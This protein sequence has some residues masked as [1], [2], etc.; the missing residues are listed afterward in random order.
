MNYGLYLSAA[1]MRIN[2]ERVDVMANNLA[3]VRTNAFKQDFT[4]I[5]SR[6]SAPQE[7][8]LPPGM[9]FPVLDRMGGGLTGGGTHTDFSQG[10]LEG[11]GR[12]LDLALDGQGFFVVE[13]DGQRC[14]TRDGRLTRDAAGYLVTATGQHRVLDVDGAAI[15]VGADG[16]VSVDQTGTVHSGDGAARLAVVLPED[17][18]ALVKAGDGLYRP[19]S[20]AAEQ[21]APARVM[22]GFLE[23]SGTES[24]TTL[25]DLIAAQRAYDASARMIRFADTMLGR[26]VNDIAQTA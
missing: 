12:D 2:A 21:P 24:F 25:V 6:R 15:H 4:V 9:A 18:N 22:Q 8:N 10:S 19:V 20:D 11:T 3:N 13:A 16:P 14:Y 17:R 7:L 5:R 23:S 1:A 26:A